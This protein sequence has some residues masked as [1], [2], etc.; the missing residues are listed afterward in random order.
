M[1]LTPMQKIA[2]FFP[3]GDRDALLA[4][5]QDRG[6]VQILDLKET[7]LAGELETSDAGSGG[8]AERIAGDLKRAI[9]DLAEFEEGGG[10]FGGLG[11]G[12]LLVNEHEFKKT[13]EEFDYESVL[14]AVEDIDNGRNELRQ[15]RGHR[16]NDIDRL[17]PWVDLDVPLEDLAP[18]SDAGI[19]AG[20]I[21][22]GTTP[23]GLLAQLGEVSETADVEV[24]KSA[25]AHSHLVVFYHRSEEESVQDVLRRNDFEAQT[26]EGYSGYARDIV[27][28]ARAE[29]K[30]IEAG[31]EQIVGKGREI[32]HN[33]PNLMLAYDFYS[34]EAMRSQALGLI[35][36]TRQAGVLEGWI[37]EKDFD[38][39]VKDLSAHVADVEVVK[40]S[41]EEGEDPPIALRNRKPVWPFE[42]ITEMYGMPQAREVDPT[43]LTAPFFAL[44]FGFCLTDAGYGIV[45]AVLSLVLMKYLKGGRKLLWLLFIGGLFTVFM[46][47]LTGGWFGLNDDTIPSWLGWVGS[48]RKSL[49]LFDPFDSPMTMFGLAL[50]LGFIQVTFGL[51]IAMVEN[52][53]HR[54]FMAAVF[55]QLTWIVLLWSLVLYA[56]SKSGVVPPQYTPAFKYA[57]L[58][59]ALGII[60]LSYRASK[61]PGARLAWG[62]YNLYGITGYLGDVLSYTR[63]LALGLA[64]GGIGMV[65]NV[66]AGMAKGIPFV[67]YPAM[68]AV[69]IGGHAF[70]LAVNALG[71]FVHSARLQYVEF[72]PKFF[73]GGGKPFKPFKKELKF[74]RLIEEEN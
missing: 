16:Q 64:T 12:K 55:D 15:R 24:V 62:F 72:Y 60:G 9:D 52:L 45:L 59:A 43:P 35:G 39:L 47:A 58:G 17:L 33:K 14:R 25:E 11:G 71:G 40:I 61:S 48:M 2:V 68:V 73:E 57:A 46:G 5:L 37:A 53:R 21:A 44:F 20:E 38:R 49:M 74:T 30:E 18:R 10:M 26:F 23:E 50:I 34:Q 56:L 65:I 8:D 54:D 3:I 63:L 67:G 69:L 6:K 29:I 70:N 31:L 13:V 66:V 27:A 36:S 19:A 7:A 4:H 1:A 41:P 51:I 22:G 42:V 28:D 32:V